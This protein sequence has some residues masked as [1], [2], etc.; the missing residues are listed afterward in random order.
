MFY[1][2][3][4]KKIIIFRSLFFLLNANSAKH[5]SK[6]AHFLN[7]TSKNI[8]IGSQVSLSNFENRKKVQNHWTLLPRAGQT[9]V[10]IV[11]IFRASDAKAFCWCDGWKRSWHKVPLMCH[12]YEMLCVH[13]ALSVYKQAYIFPQFPRIWGNV[14]FNILNI[15]QTWLWPI[16]F[17]QPETTILTSAHDDL[18]VSIVLLYV[19]ENMCIA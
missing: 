6:H 15:Y 12:R 3:N 10:I 9:D 2:K 11:C 16:D 4:V 7:W 13:A 14:I 19:A 8:P 17:M 5:V 18:T 1:F